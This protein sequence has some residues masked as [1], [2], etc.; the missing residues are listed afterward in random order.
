VYVLS[1]GQRMQRGDPQALRR[2]FTGRFKR[3]EVG[4]THAQAL[5]PRN[6]VFA[7]SLRRCV[8]LI[9]DTAQPEARIAWESRAR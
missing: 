1:S 3:Y 6:A 8:E 4:T 7:S 9:R 5:D 2:L